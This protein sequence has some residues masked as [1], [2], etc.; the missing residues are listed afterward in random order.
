[1]RDEYALN[2]IPNG[3]TTIFCLCY[4]YLHVLITLYMQ[5]FFM[6]KKKLNLLFIQFLKYFI[7]V[8]KINL[9]KGRRIEIPLQ[10]EKRRIKAE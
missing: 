10:Y 3:S 8:S 9:H 7:L 5:M 4:L 1:M 6:R 2:E